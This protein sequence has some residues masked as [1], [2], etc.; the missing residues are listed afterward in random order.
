MLLSVPLLPTPSV[1]EPPAAI[2]PPVHARIPVPVVKATSPVPSRVPVPERSRL[3]VNCDGL[4]RPNDPVP[5]IESGTFTITLFATADPDEIRI[6]PALVSIWTSSELLGTTSPV[7]LVPSNQVDPSPPPSQNLV[8]V[9]GHPVP[10][11][12]LMVPLIRSAP[13]TLAAMI[14]TPPAV[15]VNGSLIARGPDV[16]IVV[17]CAVVSALSID[18]PPSPAVST[19]DVP[20]DE[21]S[22]TGPPAVEPT[23]KLSTLITIAPDPKPSV[24]AVVASPILSVPVLLS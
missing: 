7:Q 21:S 22:V 23:D 19:T 2:A 16:S 3:L 17:A 4:V 1:K 11:Q 18:I 9:P 12:L 13:L 8:P 24:P 20:A 5:E 10:V 14:V 6:V 15:L